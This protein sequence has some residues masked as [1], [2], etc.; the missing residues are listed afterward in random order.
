MGIID[1]ILSTLFGIATVV[2]VRIPETR[3]MACRLCSQ[4][5]SACLEILEEACRG[6]YQC[7]FADALSS[8]AS[9]RIDSQSSVVTVRTMDVYL[10]CEGVPQ[11]YN[12]LAMLVVVY[13]TGH[14]F[15]SWFKKE[16]DAGL[17]AMVTGEDW[18]FNEWLE[19]HR[20]YFAAYISWSSNEVGY[21][22]SHS[23][24][25]TPF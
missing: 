4:M 2:A 20:E 22:L 10:W 24:F 21:I 9:T 5:F 15:S 25:R 17:L 6:L 14:R 1:S 18:T 13:V 23:A 16:L 19:C 8:N 7:C 11:S 12:T 3:S